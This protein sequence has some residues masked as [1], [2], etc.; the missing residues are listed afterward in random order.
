MF[1]SFYTNIDKKIELKQNDPLSKIRYLV[2]DVDGTM[3]DG[4]VYYDEKGNE[5]KKFCTRDA[6][7]FFA[8]KV[9]G[10]FIMVITGRKCAATERRMRELQ[11]DLLE[12]EVVNK[13]EYL[14]KYI[15]KNSIGKEEIAFIG[16]D[17]NDYTAMKLA[18]FCACPSDAAEE[19]KEISDYI[20]SKKGGEGAVRE[21]IS[22]LLKQ[23][24]QW[25][26]AI[27]QC[28]KMGR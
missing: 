18:G 10:I 11:V 2:I 21:I 13:T 6:A 25:Q 12:Q 19:V 28:Y 24:G 1:T 14:E 17:L 4:G 5:W 26:Q 22:Y 8:A 7:G 20:S 15:S 27:E 16:D 3:T 9:C 23:R